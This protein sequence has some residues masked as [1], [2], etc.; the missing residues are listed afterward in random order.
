[1]RVFNQ[2]NVKGWSGGRFWL[3]AQLLKSRHKLVDQFINRI[4]KNNRNMS[5]SED[6]AQ[7]PC[8]KLS[9]Y[10]PDAIKSELISRMIFQSNESIE[11][12][13]D[14]ILNYEFDSEM[15]PIEQRALQVYAY[16]AKTPEFQII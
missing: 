8:L 3:T 12:D 16:L 11:F 4:P 9:S 5:I 2:D 7:V 14:D 10:K 13:I 15:E 1:M 6:H